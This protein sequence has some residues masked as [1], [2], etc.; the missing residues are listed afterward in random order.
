[1]NERTLNNV[2]NYGNLDCMGS[3]RNKSKLRNM[4]N[5]SKRKDKWYL[6][7]VSDADNVSNNNESI[8]RNR[9]FSVIM[10]ITLIRVLPVICAMSVR[11]VNL[12]LREISV[13][14]AVIRI[15][16]ENAFAKD[17]KYR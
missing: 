4:G 10:T 11:K 7:Y 6:C 3:F 12:V 14:R 13:T 2:G 1:M 9:V 16:K 5:I 15:K 17:W 8:F